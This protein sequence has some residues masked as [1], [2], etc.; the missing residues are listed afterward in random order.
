MAVSASSTVSYGPIRRSFGHPSCGSTAAWSKHQYQGPSAMRLPSCRSC[1]AR[2]GR[3]ADHYLDWPT[4]SSVVPGIVS[5]RRP[6]PASIARPEYVDQPGPAPFTGSE[7]K[8]S[9]TI[10]RIRAAAQLAARALAEVGKRVD[11]KSTRLNSSHVKI[12]YAVF[13]LKKKKEE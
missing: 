5:P 10:E 11:R 7:V 8:D 9:E 2:L 3:R 6:V 4:M 13:C 1:F 12:S